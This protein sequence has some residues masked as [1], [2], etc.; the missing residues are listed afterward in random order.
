MRLGRVG[1]WSGQ[2]RVGDPE[3][4]RDAASELEELGYGAIW[5]PGGADRDVLDG[6]E[7]LLGAT[8]H[9]VVATGIVNIWAYAPDALAAQQ[10]ALVARYPE[11]FLLGLGVGHAANVEGTLDRRYEQPFAEMVAFLDGLDAASPPVPIAER[12]LAAL[13]PRMLALARDRSLGAH[14]YLAD[15]DHTAQARTIL[16][17]GALLA[18]EQMVVLNDDAAAA[19]AIAR[20]LLERYLVRPN[21]TNNLRRLG[22]GEEDLAGGGSDRLI[23]AIVSWGD[24]AAIGARVQEQLDAGADHV[25]IQVLTDGHDEFPLEQWRR[26]APALV[27]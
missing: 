9:C 26:L 23:D 15:P 4:A 14:P 11:R 7:T 10:R 24:E 3:A 12:A 16:G 18:P 19:R 2:L 6:V 22:Y 27:S 1:I 8:R 17:P 5:V 21:Y 20:D 13:G 25:C